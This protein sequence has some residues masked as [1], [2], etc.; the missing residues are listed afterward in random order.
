MRGVLK[1]MKR[2]Y[3]AIAIGV[4]TVTLLGG[5]WLVL[6]RYQIEVSV[7]PTGPTSSDTVP[8]AAVPPAPPDPAALPSPSSSPISES[9]PE[10]PKIDPAVLAKQIGSL[11]VSN[12]TEHPL[13]IVLLSQTAKPSETSSPENR[14]GEF[15][16]PAHWDFAP[17]EGSGKGLLLSL[18]DRKIQL[19]PG[20][21]LVAFAQDG[22]RSYWGPYVVGETRRSPVW[23]QQ[24]QEWRLI[25]QKE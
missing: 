3:P 15:D 21:V 10:P 16:R 18:P 24:S 19:K 8:S 2:V 4:I 9:S 17:G 11:R 25:L 7:G 6:G 22:S 13:R 14:P 5:A 1:D 23:N 20:D 12:Q